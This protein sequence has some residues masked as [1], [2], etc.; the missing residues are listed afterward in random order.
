[1]NKFD[2][3]WFWE[4]DLINYFFGDLLEQIFNFYQG[5]L[6]LT[7]AEQVLMNESGENDIHIVSYYPGSFSD[8]EALKRLKTFRKFNTKNTDK[9]FHFKYWA[10]EDEKLAQ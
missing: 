8:P 5:P 4:L 1:V 2:D 6:R 10:I 9:F 7:Q 3:I